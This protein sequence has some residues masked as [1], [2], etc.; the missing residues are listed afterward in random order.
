MSTRLNRRELLTALAAVGVLAGCRTTS[1]SAAPEVP[2]ADANRYEALEHS[3]GALIGLHALDLTTS[4]TV[5]YRAD[6]RFAMCST[7]KAYA[8]ARVLQLAD[9][10]LADL[11]TA[12]PIEPDDIVVNSPV[13]AEAVGSSMSL[14]E[15]CAAALMRSDN[16]AGNLLLRTIGGP[17]AITEFA[18]SIGD[19]RTRL[20]RWEVELNEA[21]PGDPRDTTTPRVLSDGYRQILTGDVLQAGSRSQLLDWMKANATSAKRFRAGLPAGWTSA[22]KTGAG[23]YG[24]T[25]DAGLLIG[26]SGQRIVAVVMTRSRDNVR[27]APPFNEAI[28]DAVR[29]TL[30]QLGHIQG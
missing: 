6:D 9:G 29:L 8:A 10:G 2:G 16:T 18:R 3:H 7:F 20:D 14:R 23:D 1:S 25:N 22:D 27:D 28:A 15:I 5:E 11:N 24:S 13:T 12:I 30:T 21:L 4:A 17:P 26:P 19:G